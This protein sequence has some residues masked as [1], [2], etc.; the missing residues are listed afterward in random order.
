M[1]QRLLLWRLLLWRILLWRLLLRCGG[2]LAPSRRA[3][4][5]VIAITN[6]RSPQPRSSLSERRGATGV[7]SCGVFS[8][9]VLC[10]GASQCERKLSR[11]M[12]DAMEAAPHAMLLPVH[13]KLLNFSDTRIV[14]GKVGQVATAH[15]PI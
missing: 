1:L 10:Y 3:A 14:H 4:V 12:Q 7:F 5:L 9:G 2:D 15:A 11:G 6:G 13:N 8:C